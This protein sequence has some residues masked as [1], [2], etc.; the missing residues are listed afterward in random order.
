M[1]LEGIAKNLANRIN[2]EHYVLNELEKVAK[3]AF[4]KYCEW[5]E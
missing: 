1:K 2:Q 4:L 3:T 5:R